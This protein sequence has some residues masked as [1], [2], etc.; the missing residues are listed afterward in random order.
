MAVFTLKKVTLGDHW[1]VNGL[2]ADA[3]GGETL[4][5]AEAGKTHYIEQISISFATD[6]TV[7]IQDGAT[8]ILGPFNFTAA[9]G[10]FLRIPLVRPMPITLATALVAT[11][12][13]GA[14]C[15][16]VEGFTR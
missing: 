8:T 7:A 15:I 3:S 6:G 5:A 11:A 13:A 10:N 9:G 4:L 1:R 2:S 14:V 16:V 12:T